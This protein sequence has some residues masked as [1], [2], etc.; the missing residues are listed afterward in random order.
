MKKIVTLSNESKQSFKFA[1]D[2]F[3]SVEVILEFK[4]SQNAWYYSIIWGTFEIRNGRIVTG[5]NLLRQ[6][7][8]IIPFG[9]LIYHPDNIDPMLL[10]DFQYNGFE[11]YM[12]EAADLP[13]AEAYY[14][15]P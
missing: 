15:K 14:V 6:Y 10:D 11:F 13:L 4:L 8:N 5:L 1:L 3:E 2:G 12:L 7:R 9:I